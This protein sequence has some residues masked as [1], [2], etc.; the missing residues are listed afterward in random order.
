LAGLIE[1]LKRRKVFR[2]LV[3][4]VVAAWLLLQV[5]DLLSSVLSLPEWAPKMVLFLLAIGLVPALI[6][7]WAY[8]LT[9]EGIKRNAEVPR[10][11]GKAAPGKLR[12]TLYAAGVV[13]AAVAGAGIYWFAGAD[14]RWVRDVALPQIEQYIENDDWERAYATA[15]EIEARV[16]D[17]P[18]LDGYWSEFTVKTSIPSRPEGATV[19]RRSYEDTQADWQPL[20]RTPIHDMRIPRGFSLMRFEMPEFSEVLRIV[21]TMPLAGGWMS[22]GAE[23]DVTGTMFVV[24]PVDVVLEPAATLESAEVRVPGTQLFLDGRQVPLADFYI[25]QFEVTNREYKAF[26]DAGAYRQRGYWEQPFIRE[27]MTMAWDEAMATFADTTGRPGPSTWIGGTYPEGQEDYPVGGISWYEAMAYARFAGHELPTVHHWRRAHAPATVTWQVLKSNVGTDGPAP[28]GQYEGT[29][30]TGTSDM[31]GNVREWTANALGE[32]RAIVGGAWDDLT[33]SIPISIDL[34]HALPPFDRSPQNGLRLASVH[35]ERSVSDLLR[36]AI[37]PRAPIE[38]P[39][40]VSDDAFAVM[41]QNFEQGDAPLNATID[42]TV[43]IREWTREHISL[44]S[45]DGQRSEFLLYLPE[46]RATR[47]RTIFFW[48]SS[49]AIQLTSLD[50]YRLPVDFLL[51]SGQAIA[52]PIFERTF[53][54]GDGRYLPFASVAARD[55]AIRRFRE[56]RRIIDYLETRPDIDASSVAYYGY[57]WGGHIGALA[58]AIEPRLKVGILNQ[59]GFDQAPQSLL[60][61]VN[62]L[63]RVHQPVLQ[64]NGRYDTDFRYEDSAK[65]YFDRLASEFKKHVVEPGGHFV[66][67]SVV[68]GETLAWLDEHLSEPH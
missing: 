63:P 6:L 67:N 16:P 18:V 31:L 7:A 9:P 20:G 10:T 11:P 44:D 21:G 13:L 40:P 25:G 2:V 23:E 37:E 62:Y 50:D 3:A 54:R 64:F 43:E 55:L 68:I 1:E 42:E 24:Q 39:E 59:A 36:Q 14:Q 65:P 22:M 49:L 61:P 48:P 8:E 29:G 5:A 60:H 15:M 41:L 47:H 17:S 4:Y 52:L 51:R 30:W 57:S 46:G 33:Y 26:V 45:G 66:P 28:V 27:G 35:D 32:E 34:P 58:L 53:H 19:Y 56:M 38:V 12:G